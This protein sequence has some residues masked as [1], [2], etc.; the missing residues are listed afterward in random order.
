ME[1]DNN[2]TG[3][4]MALASLYSILACFL[5]GWQWLTYFGLPQSIIDE[6]NDDD[7]EPW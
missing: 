1:I 3:E 4:L 6:M 2:W 7:H 5:L